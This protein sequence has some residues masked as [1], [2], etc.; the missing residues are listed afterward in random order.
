[1]NVTILHAMSNLLIEVF[2]KV[3]T[4]KFSSA[5]FNIRKRTLIRSM[6]TVF[7][8]YCG[9]AIQS[10]AWALEGKKS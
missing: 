6:S 2:L 1:M 7:G 3:G 4:Y 8:Q 10:C 5:L 9:S